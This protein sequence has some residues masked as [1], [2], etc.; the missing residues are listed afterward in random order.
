[1]PAGRHLGLELGRR[2]S[3]ARAAIGLVGKL[4][5]AADFLRFRADSEAFQG[6]L[7]WLIDGVQRAAATGVMDSPDTGVQALCFRGRGASAL[8]G[9]LAP[10]AD[11]A[12]RRF[13]IAAVSEL[14]LDAELA[15]HPEVLPLVLEAVWAATAQLVVELQQLERAELEEAQRD[16]ARFEVEMNLGV[17]DAL[18]AYRAW[19]DELELDDFLALV[20]GADLEH[21]VGA[22][23]LAEEAVSPYRGVEH[24]DTPLSLRLPL[25]QAGG[26]AVC[27]WLDLIVRL[28]GWRRTV[29]SFFWSHDGDSGALLLH[30][31]R[32]PPSALRELW[33]PTGKSDEVCDLVQPGPEFRSPRRA[34]WQR[35]LDDPTLRVS[36]LLR[37]G[38]GKMPLG[39]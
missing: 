2:L 15:Q 20:F 31:G 35:L 1:V 19:T 6:L 30:L 10:S 38:G 13:P 32:V 34:R 23:A 18:N 12:G 28:T 24:P 26:A 27:F 21:A 33:M 11:Q 16:P 22:L 5:A 7:G 39:G 9:A 17:G 29:P 36:E 4:P 14:A 37:A 25:G 3:V 8:V